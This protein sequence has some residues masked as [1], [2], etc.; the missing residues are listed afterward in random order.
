MFIIS[1][2]WLF[3]FS[4]LLLLPFIFSDIELLFFLFPYLF[5]HFNLGLE[6]TFNDYLHNKNT[7][8]LLLLLTRL[9]NFEFLRNLIEFLF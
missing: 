7:L 1:Q 2:W 5:L 9:C 6:A 8:V 4:S 3:R